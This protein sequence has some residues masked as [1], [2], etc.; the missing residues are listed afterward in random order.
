[1]QHAVS[2]STRPNTQKRRGEE[3]R[4][5]A[6]DER[7]DKGSGEGGRKKEGVL[8]AELR[9]PSWRERGR[10][11][12]RPGGGELVGWMRTLEESIR[13]LCFPVRRRRRQNCKMLRTLRAADSAAFA[14]PLV[15]RGRRSRGPGRQ[16]GLCQ[17]PSR[18]VP[19]RSGASP[20]LAEEHGRHARHPQPSMAIPPIPR[21]A[22][23]GRAHV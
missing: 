20:D 13:G 11:R 7:G 1:M 23:I 14:A 19:S 10:E 5:G 15:G 3:R 12:A 4:S 17:H 21:G 8:L 6:D 2:V 18:F 16:G 9:R 22:Q